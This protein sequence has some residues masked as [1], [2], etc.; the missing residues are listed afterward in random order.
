MKP[1]SV[2][3]KEL[4]NSI[5]MNQREFSEHVG[6]SVRTIQDWETGRR[7]PPDYIPRLIRY[8][9][10]YERLC[11]RR[12]VLIA[13]FSGTSAETISKEMMFDKVAL[14]SDKTMDV[15]ILLNKLKKNDYDYIIC[16]GQKPGII[17]SIKIET[18]AHGETTLNSTAD[19]NILLKLLKQKGIEAELSSKPGNSFCNN[20]YW[21]GLHYLLENKRS[22][23]MLFLHVP[24]E[25]NIQDVSEFNRLTIEAF[26]QFVNL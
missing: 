3:I 13:F 26:D 8:Q 20:V 11:G 15:E 17:N 4:R 7:V 12:N 25:K 19:C 14:P 10:D 22:S 16:L 5:G 6:I 1:S 23:K 24:F 9:L 21:H 2:I 18:E